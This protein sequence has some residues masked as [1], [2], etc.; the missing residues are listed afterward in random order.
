MGKHRRRHAEQRPAERLWRGL[1][2]RK[3]PAGGDGIEQGGL[4]PRRSYQD[5]PGSLAQ[6]RDKCGGLLQSIALRKASAQ[7]PPLLLHLLEWHVGSEQRSA[8][9][10][11]HSS[12][13]DAPARSHAY[14]NARG[15]VPSSVRPVRRGKRGRLAQGTATAATKERLR[16][17]SVR[18]GNLVCP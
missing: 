15:F 6:Y 12:G 3:R 13:S 5:R 7:V 2:Y 1:R 17:A 11:A 9:I 16:D 14:R 8:W 4:L 18:S 10:A